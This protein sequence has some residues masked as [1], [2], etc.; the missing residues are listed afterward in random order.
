LVIGLINKQNFSIVALLVFSL[1]FHLFGYFFLYDFVNDEGEFLIN[2]KNLVLFDQPS[3]EGIYN[4]ALAPLHTF[5]H[6]F[7]FSFL[8]PD[9]LISRYVSIFCAV[10]L[11]GFFYI[12]VRNWYS[13]KIAIFALTMIAVNGVFNRFTTLATME[14]EVYFFTILTILF[15]FSSKA[16]VRRLS[17][18][19]F[20]LCLGFKPLFFYLAIPFIY[21]LLMGR[22][23]RNKFR[24]KFSKSSTTDVGIFFLGTFFLTGSIFYFTYIINPDDFLA[25]LFKG[26]NIERFNI[27]KLITEPLKYG[28]FPSFYDFI[29]RSPITCLCFVWGIVSTIRDKKKTS[30]DKFL[31]LWVFIEIIFYAPQNFVPY[32]YLIDL[33]FPLSVLS[34]KA[35][36]RDL[37]N[38]KLIKVTKFDLAQMILASIIIF[39]I[40][41]S[42][43]FFLVW[44]P[45][46]PAME[47][48]QW[49]AKNGDNYDLILSPNQISID[50]P[51]KTLSVSGDTLTVKELLTG[52][53]ITYPVLCVIQKTAAKVHKEDEIFLSTNGKVIKKIGYFW[54]YEIYE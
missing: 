12:F 33:M 39:Q 37:R 31:L 27:Y 50:I 52:R 44:K 47:A 3:L 25:T 51:Y 10:S 29:Q 6:A 42:L 21:A 19:P 22:V 13:H 36:L 49:L 30:V 53:K 34:A 14:A 5:F 9:I 20:S 23:E 2:A 1:S 41:A 24:F 15:C 35:I 38:Q 40:S 8:S 17:F 18:L 45:E 43:L 46:R 48:S 54:I 32:R 26:E 16:W 11:L 28:L 7:L 4:T